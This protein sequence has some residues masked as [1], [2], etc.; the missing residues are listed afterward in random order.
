[1][2][3]KLVIIIIV[4]II[5]IAAAGTAYL[6]FAY[7]A[8]PSVENEQLSAKTSEEIMK[9][10]IKKAT[11]DINAVVNSVLED[12]SEEKVFFEEEIA[13]ASLISSDS[14][15]ISSFGQSYNENDF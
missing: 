6:K 13:D 1:M 14:Q 4:G 9:T 11:G 8:T 15:E 5:A 7:K 3:S 10:P 12:A 2:N